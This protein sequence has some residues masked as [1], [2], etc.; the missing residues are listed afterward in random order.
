MERLALFER[1][2][3]HPAAL[4][5]LLEGRDSLVVLIGDVT[6][7]RAT[8]EQLRAPGGRQSIAESEGPRVL[9]SR[10]AV[11]TER[12]RAGGRCRCEA[13]H[14]V[15]VAGGLGVVREPGKIPRAACWIGERREGFAV[16][17]DPPVER[18]R[19]LDGEAG[20]LVPE[21]D[22]CRLGRGHARRQALAE[23][24]DRLAGKRLEQP[25]L[26]LLRDDRDRLE[27]PLRGRTK[28]RGA[29]E[30]RVPHRLRYLVG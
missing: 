9:R 25:E 1:V 23:T 15:D 7:S 30:D 6:L 20:E 12:R 5:R 28:A 29:G 18:D 2:A 14:G 27:E 13:K 21:R 11:R 10:L 17:V 3:H 16:Q 8:L 19:F 4:E 26:T 24:V 22:A